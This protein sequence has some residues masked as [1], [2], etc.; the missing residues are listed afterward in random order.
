MCAADGQKR[1]ASVATRIESTPHINGT[2]VV[3]VNLSFCHS[4]PS[5]SSLLKARALFASDRQECATVTTAI[6]N[7]NYSIV[8]QV[9][10]CVYC[11]VRD[12]REIFR[13][14][15]LRFSWET[16]DTWT[17]WK[18]ARREIYY[19]FHQQQ[20]K[21]AN[22][23]VEIRFNGFRQLLLSLLRRSECGFWLGKT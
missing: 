9:R 6:N 10:K 8:H 15:F 11:Y 4:P 7:I 13:R 14:L 17:T 1:D 3:C 16:V 20:Q 19:I 5:L 21:I 18:E 23:N 22:K 2:H 12:P